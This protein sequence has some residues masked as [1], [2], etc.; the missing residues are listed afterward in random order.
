MLLV[1]NFF[2]FEQFSSYLMIAAKTNRKTIKNVKCQILKCNSNDIREWLKI[3]ENS[4]I[5]VHIMNLTL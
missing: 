5:R 1:S 3:I 2:D 4:F